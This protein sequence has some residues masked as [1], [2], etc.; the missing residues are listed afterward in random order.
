MFGDVGVAFLAQVMHFGYEP[1]CVLV[2]VL[3]VNQG[4][5]RKFLLNKVGVVPNALLVF[6]CELLEFFLIS[7]CFTA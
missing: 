7:R 1:T 3:Y 5:S 2:F 6:V 4:W